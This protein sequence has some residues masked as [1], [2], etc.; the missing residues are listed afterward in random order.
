MDK[1][2]AKTKV[3][4]TTPAT[5]GPVV[6]QKPVVSA[7]TRP[8]AKPGNETIKPDDWTPTARDPWHHEEAVS[9]SD[10]VTGMAAGTTTITYDLDLHV[11]AVYPIGGFY[12]GFNKTSVYSGDTQRLEYL[13]K[14]LRK[15]SHLKVQIQAYTDCRGNA[16]V[17]KHVAMQRAASYKKYL[18]KKGIRGSRI[19]CKWFGTRDS[20]VSCTPCN[21]CTDEQHKRNRRIEFKIVGI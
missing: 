15:H 5:D 8:V 1:H 10:F 16:A 2:P 12:F 4:T 20:E 7:P 14:Q 17:N 18:E 6:A 9:A 19:E 11:G 21:S 3:D 13:Y